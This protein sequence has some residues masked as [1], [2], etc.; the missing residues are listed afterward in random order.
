MSVLAK[1]EERKMEMGVDLATINPDELTGEQLESL[2]QTVLDCHRDLIGACVD[3]RR[4][5]SALKNGSDKERQDALWKI[6]GAAKLAAK[7]QRLSGGQ[8]RSERVSPS[9]TASDRR[10]R[11]KS[12]RDKVIRRRMNGLTVGHGRRS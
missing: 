10:K 6:R 11:A 1:D 5:L 2:C 12:T 4:V 3:Y 8:K 7:R 9:R